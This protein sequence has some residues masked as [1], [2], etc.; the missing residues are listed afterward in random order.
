MFAS[1]TFLI[2][3]S[4]FKEW[5]RLRNSRC[6]HGTR[7]AFNFRN[8]VR[9]L[10]NKFAFWFWASWFMAFPIASWFFA[11]SFAFRLR[12]L[13]MGNA[14]GLFAYCYAL[15]AIEHFAAF[16]WALNFTFRFLAFYITNCISWL[17]ATSM[18][19]R[20]LAYWVAN[21]WAMWVITFP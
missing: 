10:T 5:E 14:V 12:C 9:I 8:A 11:Y 15:R 20:W 16:V 2:I 17:C 18:T 13:A 19:F 21:C 3:L 7:T 1:T 4:F 6:S